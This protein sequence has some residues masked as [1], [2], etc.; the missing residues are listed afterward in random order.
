MI[1]FFPR[2]GKNR[3]IFINKFLHPSLYLSAMNS[4]RT[5]CLNPTSLHN[6]LNFELPTYNDEPASGKL[7]SP[8]I[9]PSWF[10]ILQLL[11]FKIDKLNDVSEDDI[12]V[13]LPIDSMVLGLIF[14]II[15][16][17]VKFISDWLSLVTILIFHNQDI[18]CH[19]LIIGIHMWD[20]IPTD[21]IWI[22]CQTLPYLD[23]KIRKD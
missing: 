22:S 14:F 5:Q 6:H 3:D 16:R 23:S 9:I 18:C 10:S 21:N 1:A 2:V 19:L 12:Q 17:S 4:S 13:E 11:T 7:Y 15:S 8:P 20:V